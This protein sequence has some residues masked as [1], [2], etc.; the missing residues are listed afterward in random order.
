MWPFNKTKGQRPNFRDP[1][2][3]FPALR[4]SMKK[5]QTRREKFLAE[6]EAVVP[7]SRLLALIEAHYPKAGPKGGRSPMPLETMR[8]FAGIELSDDRIPDETTILNFRHLLETHALTER[9]FAEVNKHLAD[10]GITLRAGTLVDG[11]GVNRSL[12]GSD[13]S[14]NEHDVLAYMAFNEGLRSKL[15][16]TNPMERANKEIKRRTNVVGIF[17]NRE[18]VI[19]LVGALMLGQND[20]WAVS[21]RYMPVEKLNAMCNDDEAATMIADW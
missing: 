8:R 7:W 18:A 2:A 4:Q 9:L 21:R 13:R 1:G 10:H 5:K 11:E 16:S 6:M 17:R 19:R 3:A 20:E 15:H 14:S 12:R